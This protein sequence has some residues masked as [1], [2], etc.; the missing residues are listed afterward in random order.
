MKKNSLD[1]PMVSVTEF[2]F[3]LLF[4]LRFFVGKGRT[5]A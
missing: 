4:A 1:E 3:S 5:A 2:F